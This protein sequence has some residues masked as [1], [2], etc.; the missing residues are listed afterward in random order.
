MAEHNELGK[1][2]EEVA[3]GFLKDAGYKI[4]EVSW[5]FKHKEID[6]IALDGDILVFVEVKTRSESYWGNPE[7][8]V[9]RKKQRFLIQAA[10]AYIESSDYD[11]WS[12]FDVIAVTIIKGSIEINH[13]TEAFYP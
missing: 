10:E 11:A 6:I 9:T 2:G 8:F 12:R 13:I 1:K 5:S 3:L 4:L 7:D